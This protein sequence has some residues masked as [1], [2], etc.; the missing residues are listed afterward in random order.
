MVGTATISRI[1]RL[2][3]SLSARSLFLL[4]VSSCSQ[5]TF[6]THQFIVG[7]IIVVVFLCH[8]LVLQS[9][10]NSAVHLTFGMK[11]FD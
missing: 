7:W 1:H 10:L 6:G 8:H 4:A 2:M 3:W 5:S 11:H 9:V